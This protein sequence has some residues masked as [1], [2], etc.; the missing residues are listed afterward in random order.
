VSDKLVLTDEQRQQLKQL[1]VAAVREK[2][3]QR[4]QLQDQARTQRQIWQAMVG[5]PTWSIVTAD[6][7]PDMAP[8]TDELWSMIPT[9]TKR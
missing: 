3:G 8:T 2:L 1:V 7:P 4:E 9:V 5:A 6:K